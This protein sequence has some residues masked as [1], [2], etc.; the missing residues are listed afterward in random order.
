[1]QAQDLT[2]RRCAASSGI[3]VAVL[4]GSGARSGAST[5][6]RTARP[7]PMSPTFTARPPT[8]IV[9]GGSLSLLAIAVFLLFAGALRQILIEAGGEEFLA[10]TAF[11]GAVLGM[12]RDRARRRS[13]WLQ[14]CAPVTRS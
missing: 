8:G 7:W 9:I 6:R 4:F 1:M 12:R 3:A 13:T 11:G 14:L 2:A 10:T 5:C